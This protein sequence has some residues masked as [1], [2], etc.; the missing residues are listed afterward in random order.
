[1]VYVLDSYRRKG[2]EFPVILRLRIGLN[3]DFNINSGKYGTEE[4]FI[5]G[6]FKASLAE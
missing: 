2:P 5:N 6:K 1:L 3:G 4:N